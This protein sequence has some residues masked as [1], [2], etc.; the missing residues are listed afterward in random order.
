MTINDASPL[1]QR[2]P[3]ATP[4]PAPKS[5][6]ELIA[7]PAL[8]RRIRDGLMNEQPDS[9][10]CSSRYEGDAL[11]GRLLPFPTTDFIERKTAHD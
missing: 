7:D 9:G 5:P 3:A 2:M 4:I 10:G 8:I 6:V 1:P 11:A